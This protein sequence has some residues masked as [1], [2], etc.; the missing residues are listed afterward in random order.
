MNTKQITYLV[1]CIAGTLLPYSQFIPFL[2]EHGLDLNQFSRQLFATR[3]STLF[4]FDVVVS[5]L[6]LWFF[7]YTE[8]TRLKMRN[9]WVYV[10]A[11]LLVGVSLALPLFLLAREFR[12][13]PTGSRE[14][15]A[16]SP[17]EPL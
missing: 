6:V 2:R 12:V 15:S 17:T 4:A 10:V 11:N 3:I 1:L 9:L 16:S 8:G 5:S 14:R 13:D 7:V